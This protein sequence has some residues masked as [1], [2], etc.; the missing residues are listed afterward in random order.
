LNNPAHY[1]P[2]KYYNYD[3][4]AINTNF[5]GRDPYMGGGLRDFSSEYPTPNHINDYSYK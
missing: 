4:M 1:S 3:H 5:N 2:K